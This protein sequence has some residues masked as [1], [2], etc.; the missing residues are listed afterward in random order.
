MRRPLAFLLTLSLLAAGC[1]DGARVHSAHGVVRDVQP[2]YGQVVIEH[3][4]I[5][6]LMPAMTMNF[7]LA[8]P[9]LLATLERGQLIDFEV[10]F[11][12]RS[13][14]VRSASVVEPGD[15]ASP[16]AAA[17]LAAVAARRDPAP[18]FALVDQDRRPVALSDLRGKLV[19]LDFVFTHC[20]GPCPILTGAHVELQRSLAPELRARTRL[21]SISLDPERDT[22]EV[23]RAWALARGADLS[24]WSFLTGPEDEVRAVVESYGVGTT[25][26]PQGE[27]EHLVATFLIDAEGRIAERWIG[28]E[29]EPAELARALARQP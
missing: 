28:L 11:T 8:D 20:P 13:Y 9:A 26:G 18:P 19:V 17:R 2:E 16:E 29:H 6:G 3:E 1:G 22:P 25:R 14:R 7:E 12:G 15:G 4:D 5:P 24:D 23:L 27:L 10:E 21:V